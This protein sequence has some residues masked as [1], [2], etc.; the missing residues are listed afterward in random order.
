MNST[1]TNKP[2]LSPN[3][4]TQNTSSKTNS[5]GATPNQ[6]NKIINSPQASTVNTRSVS[7]TS[8]NTPPKNIPSTQPA[9]PNNTNASRPSP[10]PNTSSTATT[11]ASKSNTV[12]NNPTPPVQ[13]SNQAYSIVNDPSSIFGIWY[14]SSSVLP[15]KLKPS[16]ISVYQILVNGGFIMLR[17]G[18]NTIISP[19]SFASGSFTP[20]KLSVTANS[21]PVNNDAI[22]QGI[23]YNSSNI[24]YQT[25]S[26][27]SQILKIVSSSNSTQVILTQNP[28]S[29]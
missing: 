1:N 9:T 12:N 18:C 8:N 23:I 7:N 10:P 13:P 4:N 6:A 29:N 3:T 24:Y 26:G 11:T 5:S 28:P 20:T 22:L 25:G 2:A 21:C 17:G 19:Y 16:D 15:S 27:P 14:P